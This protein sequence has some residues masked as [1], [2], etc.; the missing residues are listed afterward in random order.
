MKMMKNILLLPRKK[1]DLKN[2]CNQLL[3]IAMIIFVPRHF[4]LIT[5]KR[6][7]LKIITH[8]LAKIFHIFFER[9]EKRREIIDAIQSLPDIQSNTIILRFY[10]ES[11]NQ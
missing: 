2:S 10:H 5:K 4:K 9:K 8:I 1:P 6:K 11:K 7:N 3:I